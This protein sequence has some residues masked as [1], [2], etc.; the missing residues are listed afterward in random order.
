M[1]RLN[2]EYAKRI[3]ED[4]PYQK[5]FRLHLSTTLTN[6]HELAEALDVMSEYT[7]S[8]HVTKER[9]DFATWIRNSIGDTTL[10]NKVQKQISKEK[11]TKLIH[12]RLIELETL[13]FGGRILNLVDFFAGIILG[14]M[15]GI[16]LAS[17]L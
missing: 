3:L 9:N 14:I 2:K 12:R 7:F 4:V 5:A 16:L 11:I 1:N 17:I 8:H 6:L 10:A 13:R 15:I